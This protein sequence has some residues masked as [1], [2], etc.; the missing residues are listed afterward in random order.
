MGSDKIYIYS[1]YYFMLK[2]TDSNKSFGA[3]TTRASIVKDIDYLTAI[4]SLQYFVQFS[5]EGNKKGD[6]EE[7]INNNASALKD[8]TLLI[9]DYLTQ[10][11]ES[12]IKDNYPYKIKIAKDEEIIKMIQEKNPDY[13]YVYINH[14]TGSCGTRF[15]HMILDCANNAPLLLDK[16]NTLS[17]G[18]SSQVG[19]FDDV[20][21]LKS[22]LGK[23]SSQPSLFKQKYVKA[24]Q[25]KNYAN[26]IAGIDKDA[27]KEVKGEDN[28]LEDVKTDEKE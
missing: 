20:A 19:I 9:S 17:L 1:Y 22:L 16:R 14:K 18:T 21:S 4:N 28:E 24:K 6:L 13:A 26:I 3:I 5:A 11:T 2:L 25:L 27:D 12:E 23:D 7:G 8:K 15:N 10:L